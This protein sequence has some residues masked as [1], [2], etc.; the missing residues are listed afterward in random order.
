MYSNIDDIK[1]ELDELCSDYICI[2]ERL[3][4]EE[5]ISDEVFDLCAISKLLFLED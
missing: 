4:V 1:K 2:L 3:K 5:I